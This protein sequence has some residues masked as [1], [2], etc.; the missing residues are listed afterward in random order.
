MKNGRQL[1]WILDDE[2][3]D[4]TIERHIYEKN[5]FDVHVTRSENLEK[6]IPLYAPY[7]DGVVA[8]IGFPC[9]KDLIERLSSCKAI[10]ISGV[11]YNHVDIEAASNKGIIVSNV[12]DYCTEEVSDHTIALMFAVTRRLIAYRNQVRSGK[13]DPLDTEPIHRFRNRTIGLLGFGR[14]ARLVAK[15]LSG[16]GVKLIAHDDYVPKQTFEEYGIT[17]VTLE[18]LLRSS[19]ILSLHVPLLPETAN[20]LHYDRLKTMPEGSFI[21]NTCRGGIINESDLKVLIEEGHIAGVGLDVLEVE[22]PSADHPLLQMEEVLITPHS[23]Y[24][25]IESV[26]ELRERTCSIIIDS[27]KGRKLAYS[28]N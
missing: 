25:S 13:W 9:G 21:V 18:E 23:S 4:H 2:W 20:L 11:G 26:R 16:F 6:D 7:A 12:P 14:I 3:F 8:Q 5:G 1:V 15:K 24:I 27:V 10:A 17:P 28:I 22:P 19:H